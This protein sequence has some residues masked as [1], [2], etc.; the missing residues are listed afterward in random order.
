M[1]ARFND[2]TDKEKK[3]F[4]SPNQYNIPS[5]VVEHQGKTF[6]IKLSSSLDGGNM[7]IPGPGAYAADKLKKANYQ[8]TMG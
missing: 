3:N 1:G 5:K 2:T 4:P 7:N 6:G 8:Y